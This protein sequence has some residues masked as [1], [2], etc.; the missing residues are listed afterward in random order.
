MKEIIRREWTEKEMDAYHRAV[1]EFPNQ[2][3][4]IQEIVET[5]TVRQI[6]HLSLKLKQLGSKGITKKVE[7]PSGI[8]TLKE[9][10]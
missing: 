9:K 4:K 10:R 7:K 8:Q 6:R 1:K 3:I 2:N 5:K